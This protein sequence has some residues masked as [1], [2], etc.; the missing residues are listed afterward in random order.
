MDR[1]DQLFYKSGVVC[2]L[3]HSGNRL[4]KR[5]PGEVEEEKNAESAQRASAHSA[6]KAFF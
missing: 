6:V 4:R 1:L 5:S 3:I 2:I